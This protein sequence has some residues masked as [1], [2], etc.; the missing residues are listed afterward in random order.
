MGNASPHED[1]RSRRPAA[2]AAKLPRSLGT[3]LL[4]ALA[5]L[6]G[7]A[8]TELLLTDPQSEVYYSLAVAAGEEI[9]VEKDARVTGDLHSNDKIDL[10]KDSV[11]HGNVSAV[12]EVK[13]KGTVDGTITEGA[14]PVPLPEILPEALVDVLGGPVS[15][16]LRSGESQ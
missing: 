16:A 2:G 9:Q 7:P 13:A 15:P 11:V 12:D 8:R 5:L 10:K 4:V 6:S 14:A 1:S 3:G